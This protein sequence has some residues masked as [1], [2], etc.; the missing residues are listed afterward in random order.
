MTIPMYISRVWTDKERIY[1]QT[2][3]GETAS[4]RFADWKLLREATPEQREH[5]VLSY[6]G[7]HWP[8]LDEDLSFEGMFAAAGLCTR[9]Q[10]GCAVAYLP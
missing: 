4:Y 2:T 9:V 1:A 6:G 7:I 5:Y 8:E 10:D 3:T